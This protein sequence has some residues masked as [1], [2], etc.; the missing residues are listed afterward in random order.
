M[1]GHN[2][3]K[4]FGQDRGITKQQLPEESYQP[5]VECRPLF[6]QVFRP[7]LSVQVGIDF[8]ERARPLGWR[9]PLPGGGRSPQGKS[10]VVPRTCASKDWSSSAARAMIASASMTRPSKGGTAERISK[11]NR[12]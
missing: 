1:Q 8:S 5:R 10:F 2:A 12:I 7:R 11:F 4:A 6:R 9:K 3:F